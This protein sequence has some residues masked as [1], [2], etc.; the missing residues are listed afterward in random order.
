MKAIAVILTLVL[1]GLFGGRLIY[2][3]IYAASVDLDTAVGIWLFDDGEG[4]V[5]ADTSGRGHDGSFTGEPQWVTGKF[6]TALEF[7]GT[8]DV[9][10]I[11][12]FGEALPSE[13]V[14]IMA[15]IKLGKVKNQ[16]LVSLVPLNR[17]SPASGMLMDRCAIH[18]PWSQA[19]FYDTIHWQYGW[20]QA[21]VDRPLGSIGKWEHWAFTYSIPRNFMKIFRNGAE[22]AST[23]GASRFSPRTADLHVGG[24]LEYSFDG[25]IDELAVFNTALSENEIRMLMGG[26]NR[27][28]AKNVSVGKTVANPDTASVPITVSARMTGE[29]VHGFSFDMAFEP[30]ILQAIDVTEGTFLKHDGAAT[31]WNVPVINNEDGLITGITCRRT[32]EDAVVDGA[33]PLVVVT[34]KPV[35]TGGSTVSLQNLR[36]S[37]PDDTEIAVAAQTGWVD[38]F[39]HGIIS[40]M[41]RDAEN[42]KPLADA[43]I[44]VRRDGYSFG[45]ETSSDETGKYTVNGVPV[46]EFEVF[47]SKY[48]YSSGV[49]KTLVRS[50]ETTFNIDFEMKPLL[51]GDTQDMQE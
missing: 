8:G 24:R 38:V 16:D 19:P 33:G 27:A 7:N 35:A 2:L 20:G 18:F 34:F 4:K 15:W 3:D 29:N 6:G 44:E 31:I 11:P 48:P 1:V 23:N 26:I 17:T 39:P 21:T 10:E 49:A 51:S 9:V 12:R 36:L 13:E 41:V 42:Q 47:A 37:A 50:G 5:T 22:V 30:S 45:L 28:Y 14:T 32:G 25:L 43:K 46:G 40:G